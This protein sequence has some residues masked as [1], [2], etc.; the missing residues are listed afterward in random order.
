MW[1]G[2]ISLIAGAVATIVFLILEF[3][4][5]F[6]EVLIALILGIATATA[7]PMLL[8]GGLIWLISYPFFYGFKLKRTPSPQWQE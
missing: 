7:W 4:G 2:L 5:D 1:Y 3:K 8:L 6:F